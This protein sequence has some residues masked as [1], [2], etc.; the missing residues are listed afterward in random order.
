MRWPFRHLKVVHSQSMEELASAKPEFAALLAE[1]GF[2][3]Q[4]TAEVQR[5]VADLRSS[6]HA[7]IPD[8]AAFRQRVRLAAQASTIDSQYLVGDRELFNEVLRAGDD[9]RAVL[10]ILNRDPLGQSLPFIERVPIKRA[11]DTVWVAPA[12]HA[13]LLKQPSDSKRFAELLT[14]L[15]TQFRDPHPAIQDNARLQV[16]D[17][18][19]R[20]RRDLGREKASFSAGIQTLESRIDAYGSSALE[21]HAR[22]GLELLNRTIE[23]VESVVAGHIEPGVARLKLR[24][25]AERYICRPHLHT[26]WMTN[27]ILH[28]LLAPAQIET[29]SR[30]SGRNKRRLELIRGEVAP[31]NY[32]ASEITNRLRSLE[33][34]GLY[35]SSLVYVL[36]RRHEDT[37]TLQV[38]RAHVGQSVAI[39]PRGQ[40]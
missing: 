17:A 40:L 12:E 16:L 24:E 7:Y 20:L 10:S 11:G 33:Q 28:A 32:D 30:Y 3:A 15:E 37:T 26:T 1:L 6:V 34:D 39:H 19:L 13:Y 27:Y 29:A 36:L 9:Q 14:N 21:P 22:V 23:D 25:A 8:F 38:R 18:I 5:L 31:G 35:F 2:D 4:R